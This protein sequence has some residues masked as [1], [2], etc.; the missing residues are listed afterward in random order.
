[1]DV[2]AAAQRACGIGSGDIQRIEVTALTLKRHHAAAVV[3]IIPPALIRMFGSVNKNVG[4]FRR[5]NGHHA[6][7]GALLRAIDCL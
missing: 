4:I 1:M 7:V 3:E 2:A 6:N 5:M